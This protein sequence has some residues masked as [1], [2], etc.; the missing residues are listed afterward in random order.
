MYKAVRKAM[1]MRSPATG[2]SKRGLNMKIEIL[3]MQWKPKPK[4]IDAIINGHLCYQGSL[5]LLLNYVPGHRDFL[6]KRCGNY[7]FAEQEGFVSVF[8][9]KARGTQ[10]FAGREITLNIE[11]AGEITFKGSLWDP[12]SFDDTSGLPEYRAVSLTDKK[13]VME[14][15]HTFYAGYVTK[16]LY[17]E[18]MRKAVPPEEV[19]EI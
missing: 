16:E 18:L 14:R 17:E 10:G 15:G 7:F 1:A 5:Q 3:D 11:G 4:R 9:Y 13:E 6:F 19:K 2:R 12:T 8:L